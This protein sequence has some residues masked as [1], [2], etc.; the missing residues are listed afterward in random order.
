MVST[1]MHDGSWGLYRYRSEIQQ[2]Y[3][4]S[5]E[6]VPKGTDRT[7]FQDTK[8]SAEE[9]IV[10]QEYENKN[11]LILLECETTDLE[12]SHTILLP[13]LYYEGYLGTSA[14][15]EVSINCRTWISGDNTG[16]IS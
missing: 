10:L 12:Q 1:I 14:N 5:L 9:S 15:G 13:V 4:T 6:Y 11:G 3:I 16:E 8:P 2:D 7:G